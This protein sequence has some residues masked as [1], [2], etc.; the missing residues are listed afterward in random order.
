MMSML[1]NCP[2]LPATDFAVAHP[3]LVVRMARTC[4]CPDELRTHQ[5]PRRSTKAQLPKPYSHPVLF[6][7]ASASMRFVSVREMRIVRLRGERTNVQQGFHRRHR[8]SF[9]V[10]NCFC[11]TFTASCA[12][13][14]I[15]FA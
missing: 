11:S 8:D 1:T 13:Y 9:S 3:S 12:S 10:S 5:V 14:L 15:T 6:T 4:D 7:V 2:A